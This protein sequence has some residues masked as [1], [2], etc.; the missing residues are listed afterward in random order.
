AAAM[1]G[2]CRVDGLRQERG[3]LGVRSLFVMVHEPRVASHV[4]GQYRRQPA[5]EPAWRLLRH[6]TQ[7]PA[8]EILDDASANSAKRTFAGNRQAAQDVG[9]SFLRQWG[10]PG[11]PLTGKQQSAKLPSHR[12]G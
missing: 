6:G 3:Q 7:N 11:L 4:G 8:P 12:R 2:N 9:T 1:F 5:L 10:S